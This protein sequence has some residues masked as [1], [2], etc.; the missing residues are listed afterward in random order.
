MMKKLHEVIIKNSFI[1][2]EI[3]NL[4]KL[5]SLWDNIDIFNLPISHIEKTKKK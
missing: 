4:S 2:L 5:V 1:F 3:L